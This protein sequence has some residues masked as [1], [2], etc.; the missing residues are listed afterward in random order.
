MTIALDA[1]GD[2]YMRIAAEQGIDPALMH[3]VAA[4]GSGTLDSLPHNGAVV[5]L[6]AVC[7]STHREK[8]SRYRHGRDCGRTHR[9]RGGL[10][11]WAPRLAPSRNAAGRRQKTM[12]RRPFSLTRTVFH[13][14]IAVL[15][16][17][18]HASEIFRSAKLAGILLGM[19]LLTFL[20]V[21]IYD[22]QRGPPLKPWHTY[23]PTNCTRE[24]TRN[25][26]LEAISGGRGSDL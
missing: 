23:I 13:S 8:L 1:L 16:K 12:G 24:K 17:V 20:V 26:G 2:T 4:I 3:R 6:L 19:V 7:G 10:S 18:D 15:E 21:R 11:P 9:P 5:T 22:T 14:I 25:C